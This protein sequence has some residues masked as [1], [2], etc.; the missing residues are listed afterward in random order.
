MVF[1]QISTIAARV[2]IIKGTL[3]HS[4]PGFES[5]AQLK[6]IIQFLCR[7]FIFFRVGIQ[8][9]EPSLAGGIRR[10]AAFGAF[11]AS[12]AVEVEVTLVERKCPVRLPDSREFVVVACR[13]RPNMP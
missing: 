13:H 6:I 12:V 3:V 8:E 10:C 7:E 4:S 9:T 11:W 1:V 2:Q 5:P